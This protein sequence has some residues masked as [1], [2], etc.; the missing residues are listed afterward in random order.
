M[1]MIWYWN[2]KPLSLPKANY[3]MEDLNDLRLSSSG[4]LAEIN[5]FFFING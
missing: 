3:Y 4:L 5:P 1:E 2:I